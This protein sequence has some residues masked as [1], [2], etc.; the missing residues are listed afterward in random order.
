MCHS[1]DLTGEQWKTLDPLIPKPRTRSTAGGVLGKAA[2]PS[3]TD[4]V[5]IEDRCALGG[6]SRPIPL[7]PDLS[8]A[9]SAV[10][11]LVCYDKDHDCSGLEA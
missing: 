11:S 1:G 5:G 7:V 4:P 2:A 8:W 3:L 9:L 6:S 10:G